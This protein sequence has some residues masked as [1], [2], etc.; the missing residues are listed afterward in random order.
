MKF[1]RYLHHKTHKAPPPI[2][3][4]RSKSENERWIEKALSAKRKQQS[5]GTFAGDFRIVRQKS[6]PISSADRS[7]SVN[8]N[9]NHMDDVELFA[10][11]GGIKSDQVRGKDDAIDSHFHMPPVLEASYC[12]VS[13]SSIS[14]VCP[15]CVCL[16][17][18]FVPHRC[19]HQ[20][21]RP[22]NRN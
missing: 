22:W 2:D 5:S 12:N 6:T 13:G 3:I 15:L 20:C 18:L 17:S 21:F 8:R 10:M 9:L 11:M 1:P 19:M 16:L 4:Q 7:V 14:Y